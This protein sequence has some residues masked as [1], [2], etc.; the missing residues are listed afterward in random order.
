MKKA[1]AK[2]K[3]FF[4]KKIV[5][6]VSIL[7]GIFAAIIIVECTAFNFRAIPNRGEV[8]DYESSQVTVTYATKTEQVAENGDPMYTIPSVRSGGMEKALPFVNFTVFQRLEGAVSASD[9]LP[10]LSAAT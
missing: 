1:F 3:E 6:K 2:I 9:T 7:L 5:K 8:R 4:S 10:S